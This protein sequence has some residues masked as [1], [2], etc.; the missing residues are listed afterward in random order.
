MAY[1]KINGID[2]SQYVNKLNITTKHKYTARENAS[3]NLLVK[4]ITAKKNVQ[5][6]I[7]PLDSS[8]LQSVMAI[9]NSFEVTV[10]YLE[11]ETDTL[12]LIKCIIPTHSVEYYSIRVGN[13]MAKAFTF[14]CEEK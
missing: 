4:Y 9:V 7:I 13:T 14:T 11:P 6:G 1:L 3:G 2:L 10:E 12:K 5:V 8:S